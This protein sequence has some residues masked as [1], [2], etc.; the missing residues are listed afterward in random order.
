MQLSE[1]LQRLA[2]GGTVLDPDVVGELLT[3]PHRHSAIARLTAREHEV[4]QLMA[5]G[6][7]DKGIA[8]RLVVSLHTVGTHVRNVFR[9]LE[10]PTGD[11]DNRRVL[12]VLTFLN[13]Q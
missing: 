1:A 4:L 13:N 3:S 9:R 12:A 2:V 7:S 5:E 8:N 10:L 6:L 11:I